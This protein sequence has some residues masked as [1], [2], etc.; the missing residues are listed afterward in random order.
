M[1]RVQ[2]DRRLPVTSIGQAP[3]PGVHQ[4]P[5]NL[6]PVAQYDAAR[7][8]LGCQGQK[9][10]NHAS[11]LRADAPALPSSVL[12]FPPPLPPGLFSDNGV[13]RYSSRLNENKA[14]ADVV[15]HFLSGHRGPAGVRT[16]KRLHYFRRLTNI[17]VSLSRLAAPGV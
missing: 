6:P 17:S 2:L 7:P 12:L 4:I 11:H 10:A 8:L 3:M 14:F 9:A 15:G 1:K 13:T 5:T 16:E